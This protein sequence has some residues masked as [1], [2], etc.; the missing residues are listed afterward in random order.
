MDL[1]PTQGDEKRG[2]DFPVPTELSSRPKRSGG[3][4]CSADLSWK[5]FRQSEAERS[6]VF[7]LLN[8]H[9]PSLGSAAVSEQPH[10]VQSEWFRLL[11]PHFLRVSPWQGLKPS[12]DEACCGTA[13]AVP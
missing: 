11:D 6:A 2:L 8:S 7:F 10:L 12:L 3:T 4:C 1:R 13:E 5:C 9:T